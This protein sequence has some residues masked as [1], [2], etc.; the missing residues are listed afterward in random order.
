MTALTFNRRD[1]PRMLEHLSEALAGADQ[2]CISVS[3][4]RCS[5]VG[6]LLD[7][8]RQFLRAGGQG[9]L[10][11]SDYLGITQPEALSAVRSLEG[12]ECRVQSSGQGFHSKFY[13]F[14]GEDR[15]WVG[16]SNLSRG[17]LVDNLEANLLSREPAVIRQALAGFEALWE[18]PDVF[19]LTDDWLSQYARRRPALQ[20]APRFPPPAAPHPNA[21]QREALA[22]LQA[23]RSQGER[24]AVVVAA[25]GVGKTYLAAFAAKQMDA[26]RVLFVSH[27][28]EHLTQA[29]QTF[30]RVFGDT[31]TT[32]ILGGGRREVG[33]ELLF[34]SVQSLAGLD[35]SDPI[36]LLVVDEFHHAAAASY[37]RLLQ[38]VQPGFLLGLTA[39]PERQ[40]GQDIL[41]LCD[42][43]IAYEVRLVEAIRRGW[44]LPFHYF[45][46]ADETVAWDKISWRSDS[47]SLEALETAL[48]LEAR[49][50][51]VLRAALE[52]GFDGPRR[53]TVGFCAGVRHARFMADTFRGLGLEATA[54]T[55]S[56]S[57][58]HRALVLEQ[59][60]DPSHPL[61]WLFVADLLNEGVD[62]P[63][64]NSLLFLRPTESPTIFLQ[65]LGRGLRL[66]PGCEVL[67][68]LDFVGHHR[69]A[70]TPLEVLR[71]PRQSPNA[72]TRMGITPPAGCELVLDNQTVEILQKVHRHSRSKKER[73]LD[74]YRLLRAELGSPPLPIDLW[75]REDV[76]AFGDFRA[77]HKEWIRLRAAAGDQAPW[78]KGLHATH[79]LRLLLRA[80][81]R[82]WQQQRVYAYALLY[83]MVVNRADP[84]AGYEAFFERFPRW[85]CEHRPLAET[86]AARTL[87]K[88]LRG[89]LVD[90]ALPEAVYT[91]IPADT[92]V[93]QVMGRLRLTLEA[94]HRVRHGGV[95]RTPSAL[96][97]HRFYARAEVVNHFGVQYDPALHGRGVLYF[98]RH[99]VIL[100]KLDTSDARE[101]YQY[102]NRVI[103]AT[104]LRWQSQN[105]QRQDNAA[106]QR[107]TEHRQRGVVLHIFAQQGGGRALVYL[108]E[109]TVASVEGDGPM[110][111]V[112][113]LSHPISDGAA[114]ELGVS[115][116]A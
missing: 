66:S 76:P 87:S 4:L 50:K 8:L 5:G 22:Q 17:G 103:D 29:Q 45:G 40:D 111:V 64:I 74:A 9:R 89:V 101:G 53:A 57:V 114:A 115:L 78:E 112:L 21:A 10:L 97:V 86:S 37:R 39:T 108:G 69:S 85:R 42:H 95:L 77:A 49:A 82:N 61:E 19:A 31:V 26:R 51:F 32:G 38:R 73:C 79:P 30:A 6:L 41:R 3:F 72:A 55:G 54:L 59:F 90:G 11:T 43:N 20:P 92:L 99:A 83:G 46:I 60:G 96:I 2:F 12:L 75:G 110:N 52:R 113:S 58:A 71:D 116:P 7:P 15:L 107:I 47:R 102:R 98:G 24:R 23:L 25:P 14:L 48:L 63:Q 94:D 13:T 91:T 88:R 36:D 100:T 35:L 28:L 56:D 62:V 68:V 67:T 84:G 80:C 65:Q 105:Q 104:H 106:G 33:A 27:R 81:E 109:G 1:Q 44:L 34:A 18:R 70:W 16:S 93:A